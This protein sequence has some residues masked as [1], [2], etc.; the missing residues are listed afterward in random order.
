MKHF[1]LTTET[2]VGLFGVTLFRVELTMDCKWGKIGLQARKS[3]Q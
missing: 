2:K 1:K 3:K